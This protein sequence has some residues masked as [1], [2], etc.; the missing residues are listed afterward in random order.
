MI[1]KAHLLIHLRDDYTCQ[2][3]DEIF[4]ALDTNL[5]VDHIFPKSCSMFSH[6]YNLQT[7]CSEC[8]WEKY[9]YVEAA[10]PRMILNAYEKSHKYWNKKEIEKIW[11]A[12]SLYYDDYGSFGPSMMW[13]WPPMRK[14]RS[15]KQMREK[16]WVS[17]I[18]KFAKSKD[19]EHL[20]PLFDRCISV[21]QL[22]DKRPN[23]GYDRDSED[24][25]WVNQLRAQARSPSYLLIRKTYKKIASEQEDTAMQ[26]ELI[27]ECKQVLRLMRGRG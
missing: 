4:G 21:Q 19:S 10:Q 7:L 23:F 14:P 27:E 2:L 15:S 13:E 22:K 9:D 26:M 17:T 25:K 16:V 6:P 12:L 5:N 24:R 8:N 11:G 3:C 18:R 20:K 1:T